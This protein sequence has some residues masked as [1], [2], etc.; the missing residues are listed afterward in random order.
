MTRF[1]SRGKKVFVD[2]EGDRFLGRNVETWED[3]HLVLESLLTR[4]AGSSYG[5]IHLGD[6]LPS[7]VAIVAL[8]LEPDSTFAE[9]VKTT[10]VLRQLAR[11]Q[12]RS[13]R[14]HWMA[15]RLDLPPKYLRQT[16]DETFLMP[17]M[18]GFEH[19]GDP[20]F[21]L[22]AARMERDHPAFRQ[23][24]KVIWE[25][26]A[27]HARRLLG[28]W[29][30][31]DIGLVLAPQLLAVPGN[32]SATLGLVLA[33][34]LAD[35]PVVSIVEHFFWEGHRPPPSLCGQE[36]WNVNSH[37]EEVWSLLDRLYPWDDPFWLHVCSSSD[38]ARRLVVEKGLNPANVANQP[39][40]VDTDIFRPRG[41]A[42][43]AA[44]LRRLNRL[45]DPASGNPVSEDIHAFY[46]SRVTPLEPVILANER[47]L[48]S[49]FS[50][51]TFL[52]LQ[53]TRV[54]PER[55]LELDLTLLEHLA[56]Q[57]TLPKPGNLTLLV[58]GPVSEGCEAYAEKLCEAAS[59]LMKRLPPEQARRIRVA[60]T[61]GSLLFDELA[62][63]D[64]TIPTVSEVYAVADLALVPSKYEGRCLPAAEA[65]A[66]GVPILANRFQ[67]ESLYREIVGPD[68]PEEKR[69]LVAPMPSSGEEIPSEARHLLADPA[70]RRA[71]ASHNRFV[72]KKRFSL[73]ILQASWQSVLERVS[74]LVH[75]A[76]E[77]T[78]GAQMALHRV[79]STL[80]R[81][82]HEAVTSR[83]RQYLPGCHDY[84]R[85]ATVRGLMA[86]GGYVWEE[87][88]RRRR[89]MSEAWRLAGSGTTP[90]Q[91]VFL[92]A[93]SRVLSLPGPPVNLSDAHLAYLRRQPE[94]R[95][96]DPLTDQ[97]IV[98]VFWALAER[99]LP[100]RIREYDGT[101][102]KLLERAL[103]LLLALPRDRRSTWIRN[104]RLLASLRVVENLSESEQAPAEL[105]QNVERPLRVDDSGLFLQEVVYHPRT[106]VH[107]CGK[108]STLPFELKIL[109][110]DLLAHWH[111]VSQRTAEPHKVIFVAK[112]A[113][114]L[115]ESTTGDIEWLMAQEPFRELQKARDQGR[116]RIV[117][118]ENSSL[119]T[120][121]RRAG[122]E[123]LR[124]LEDTNAVVTASGEANVH[125]LDILARPSFRFGWTEREACAKFL[126]LEAGESFFLFVPPGIRIAVANPFP[127][128][129]AVSLSRAVH[130]PEFRALV[131]LAGGTAAAM[132]EIA[133]TAEDTGSSLPAILSSRLRHSEGPVVVAPFA[134]RH[135][136]G[137][138]YTG[139]VVR[140]THE[141]I[142]GRLR[143]ALLRWRTPN[144]SVLDMAKRFESETG[145]RVVA[146]WGGGRTL[147]RDEVE[148]MG[149]RPECAGTPLGLVVSRGQV[150]CPPLGDGP[151]LAVLED[152]SLEVR[153]LDLAFGGKVYTS[154]PSAPAISWSRQAVNPR[155]VP[156]DDT[157]VYSL[158]W[159]KKEIPIEGRVLIVLSGALVTRV[160]RGEG[161][162][163]APFLPVGLH[164]TVPL[165]VYDEVLA[166][167]YFE[168]VRVRYELAWP[169]SW[170][171]IEDAIQ[172]GPLLLRGGRISLPAHVGERRIRRG[173]VAG[174]QKHY[175]ADLRGPQLGVGLTPNGDLVAVAVNGRIRDSVGCTYRELATLLREEGAVVAMGF[176]LGRSTVLVARGE[177][178]NVPPHSPFYRRRPHVAPPEPMP[179]S[180][181][182]VC[183]LEE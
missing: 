94:G 162:T 33:A 146:A 144:D 161:R 75:R 139:T 91:I 87:R 12:G 138:P 11:A 172:A 18:G 113:P 154:N 62:E 140:L 174:S 24:P 85:V 133:R 171:G 129:D 80:D 53:P 115:D 168:G 130:S 83:T 152:G 110:Q 89:L 160:I 93:C 74:T 135:K 150:L 169:A 170:R 34:E 105:L 159:P 151:I 58:T 14:F 56:R 134:G 13:I 84:G 164:V 46:I 177:V 143:F 183:Y 48:D 119:G 29:K 132:R 73:E 165:D 68:L 65:A 23:L 76:T 4:R 116:F 67:P 43:R 37:L 28:Y 2:S 179:A 79:L 101:R 31:F 166:P 21:R 117:G 99:W 8:D 92:E 19:W 42:E 6:R 55:G 128:Q 102:R 59:E 126:G 155:K 176:G 51:D 107:F 82:G 125:T 71:A 123:L 114:L 157:A 27:G 17:N 10:R 158:T 147:G 52:L 131:R 88:E 96:C 16:D 98:G 127:V 100:S 7:E 109:A 136:D 175:A 141:P 1:P 124:Y 173:S 25:Q 78:E 32:V 156:E 9:L 106:L 15:R 39:P 47:G 111:S 38:Q 22:F 90:D 180:S 142:K 118:A 35:L 61:F 121:L 64:H 3:L 44:I 97:Q 50:A 181:A 120:D 72:A 148:R 178:Q 70:R 54:A 49:S 153:N 26:A 20:Y 30:N 145:R 60:F 81:K 137:Q 77:A 122:G 182:F 40:C 57:S 167:F 69:L 149:L 103:A 63:P 95:L 66:A 163:S 36:T 108:T 112:S 45:F 5:R 86:P 104:L 41:T